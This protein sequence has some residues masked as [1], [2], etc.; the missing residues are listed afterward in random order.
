MS[1]KSVKERGHFALRAFTNDEAMAF[2]HVCPECTIHV[3]AGVPDLD[4]DGN[5]QTE[6]VVFKTILPQYEDVAEPTDEMF[7][8]EHG[9]QVKMKSETPDLK[10]G[11]LLISH[12]DEEAYEKALASDFM[13]EG[14]AIIERNRAARQEEA[15]FRAWQKAEAL[16]RYKAAQKAKS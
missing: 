7:V 3:Y 10:I 8:E 12:A 14:K 4:E 6:K 1:L 9:V 11:D 16:E 5:I 13:K 2:C 15:D